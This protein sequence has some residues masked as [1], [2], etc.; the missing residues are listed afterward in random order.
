MIQGTYTPQ[1]LWAASWSH[2]RPRRS[3]AVVGVLLAGAFV[4]ALWAAFFGRFS[5]EAGWTRWVMIAVGIYLVGY[6]GVGI[7]YFT[8]RAFRQRKD[9]QRPCKFTPSESGLGFET[10][11][12][13]G[14][15]PWSDYLKWKEGKSAFLLYMSD[16]MYQ[17]LP[18]RFFSS[19]DEVDAF[20]EMVREKVARHEA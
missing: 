13:Q 7:P 6:F 4:W 16:G 9:L 19:P 15:K 3:L 12:A 5:A 1:D 11:G 10:E 20:R 17:V 18:K 14:A 2:I 8:R